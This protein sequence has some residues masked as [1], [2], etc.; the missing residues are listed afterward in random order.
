MLIVRLQFPFSRDITLTTEH[1]LSF[2]Y[3]RRIW[4][5]HS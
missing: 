2:F 3:A 4:N 1:D 5:A